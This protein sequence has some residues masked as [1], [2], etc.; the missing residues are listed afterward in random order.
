MSFLDWG[1]VIIVLRGQIRSSTIIIIIVKGINNKRDVL[2]GFNL[3]CS[4]NERNTQ[5]IVKQHNTNE[6]F[7]L[8]YV[9]FLGHVTDSSHD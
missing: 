7:P 5:K 4:S 1:V 6:G 2:W 9:H 8:F 3:F